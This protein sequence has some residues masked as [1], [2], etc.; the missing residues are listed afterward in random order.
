MLEGLARRQQGLVTA[1]QMAEL[2]FAR[3]QVRRSLESGQLVQVRR[4]VFRLCGAQPNWRMAAMAAVLAGGRLA[5]LSHR[6]AGVLWDVIDQHE[7]SGPLEITAPGLCRLD[8]VKAHRAD[9]SDRE[10][11]KRFGLPVTTAERT[12]LDLANSVGE[13]RLGRMCDEAL[14]RQIVTIGKLRSVVDAHP[15]Q[16]RR[17]LKPIL[18]VLGDRLP[19]YDPGANDWEQGMDRLWDQMGLPPAERQYRVRIGRRTYRLD[20]AILD[21]KI[22]V[23]WN[24]F[25]AHGRRSNLDRDSDRRAA[26]AAAGWYPLDF[27]SRSRPEVICR[28][29]LA[30]VDERRRILRRAE[31]RWKPDPARGTPPA[32]VPPTG[33]N[34]RRPAPTAA[35]GPSSA[36]RPNPPAHPLDRLEPGHHPG[37][38]VVASRGPVGQVQADP[39]DQTLVSPRQ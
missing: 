16:G 2:G 26:L 7:Q 37:H 14:R 18:A 31:G 10:K 29:V 5:V 36:T 15:G 24:G 9:L 21:L 38:D 19:G 20:R 28:T 3:G 33:P 25:D 17:K 4:G 1:S 27:T 35:R 13:E 22:A 34:T 39:V 32:W 8:S 23:E 6:S 30:V 12:L 11:T